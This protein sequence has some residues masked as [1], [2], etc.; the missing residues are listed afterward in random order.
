MGGEGEGS[1]APLGCDHSTQLLSP[2]QLPV[3]K[4]RRQQMDM[5]AELKK[6]QMVKEPLIYEGKD[7][8]IEDI[9]SGEG[10][11]QVSPHHRRS[12]GG[13]RGCHRSWRDTKPHHKDQTYLQHLPIPRG[14]AAERSL[15]CL[16][17]LPP[18]LLLLPPLSS[19]CSPSLSLDR[20]AQLSKLS[21]SRPGRANARPGSSATRPST[22][23]ALC[24]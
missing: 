19:S 8:A 13:S 15:L 16:T 9:I 20:S 21:L 7:G 2:P 12:A 11:F 24:R 17:S 5:I 1:L 14:K 18:L 10:W 6:R 4:A 3:Q 23:R 22:R